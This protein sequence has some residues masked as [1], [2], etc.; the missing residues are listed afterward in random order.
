M[1]TRDF[2]FNGILKGARDDPPKKEVA[3]VSV[4]HQTKHHPTTPKVVGWS[5]AYYA[6]GAYLV[7]AHEIIKYLVKEKVSNVTFLNQRNPKSRAL[8]LSSISHELVTELRNHFT[9]VQ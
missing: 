1:N 9:S 3:Q 4:V 8:F 6:A 2:Q 5:P 7:N